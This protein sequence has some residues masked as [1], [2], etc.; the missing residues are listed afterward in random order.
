MQKVVARRCE[1]FTVLQTTAENRERETQNAG[2]CCDVR[3]RLQA[4][5]RRIKTKRKEK[6]ETGI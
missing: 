2:Q 6:D 1:Q 3:F 4:K 5:V